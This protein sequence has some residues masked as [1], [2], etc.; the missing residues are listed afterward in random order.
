MS[1]LSRRTKDAPVQESVAQDNEIDIDDAELGDLDTE[2]LELSDEVPEP[3][4]ASEVED[5]MG[6]IKQ[7][8][9]DI[10]CELQPSP[11]GRRRLK[12]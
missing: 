6:A 11:T 2:T 4:S 7:Q 9:I 10:S 1:F 5:L 12:R 8:S 3:V